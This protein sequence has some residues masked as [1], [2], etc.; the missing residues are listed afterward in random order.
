VLTLF[1]RHMLPLIESGYI[2]IAQPPLYRVAKK[3]MQEYI[4]TEKEMNE[5]VLKL[6]TK[7]ARIATVGKGSRVY[8]EKEMEKIINLLIELEQLSI[9]MER[10]SVPFKEYLA[11][12]DEKKNKYPSYKFSENQKPIFV[13]KEDELSKYG[14]TE[15]LNAVEIFE[16]HRLKEI[17]G[18]L[19]KLDISIKD[20]LETEKEKLVVKSEENEEELPCKSLKEVYQQ[21]TKL[22]T[23]G[24][25][26]QRYKGLGEMNPEQ[27]WESTMDPERRT[28]VKVSLEDT[29]EADR[30]FTLLMGEEAE[31]RKEFIH[32]YAHEVKNLDI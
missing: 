4:H 18:E 5:M 3:G 20:Y 13:Y 16:S 19:E 23:K 12:I 22:A 10:K 14:E 24:M 25:N 2:Y 6:G 7:S 1:Y 9:A 28:L 15:E 17:G 32:N 8:T 11:A 26:I 29:V 31:P 27:L 30:I 21:V